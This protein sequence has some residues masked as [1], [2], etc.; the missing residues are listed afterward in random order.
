MVAIEPKTS[1]PMGTCTRK[2]SSRMY[3]KMADHADAVGGEKML[4][5]ATFRRWAADFRPSPS[6]PR[7]GG[8]AL[9]S[10]ALAGRALAF[11][12]ETGRRELSA[13]SSGSWEGN[14][15]VL[16]ALT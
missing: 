15:V 10:A 8:G 11:L 13:V 9:R 4:S 6:G 7:A 16:P 2:S 14:E 3:P 12:R 5:A 1:I